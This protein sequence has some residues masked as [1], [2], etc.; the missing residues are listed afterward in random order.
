MRSAEKREGALI[1]CTNSEQNTMVGMYKIPKNDK[2]SGWPIDG[3][4]MVSADKGEGG[5]KKKRLVTASTTAGWLKISDS[6]AGSCGIKPRGW[7]SSDGK[8][9]AF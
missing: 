7:K 3:K 6:V 2:S 8:E 4:K 1:P 9:K 5:G